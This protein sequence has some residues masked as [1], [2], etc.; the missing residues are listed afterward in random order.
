MSTVIT[1]IIKYS[2][3]VIQY[4]KSF[5]FSVL[6]PQVGKEE[7]K[8]G[9]KNMVYILNKGGNETQVNAIKHLTWARVTNMNEEKEQK[10]K[11]D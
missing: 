10:I 3:V 2:K 4:L 1:K 8:M 9:H 6:A 5:R 11:L 7:S